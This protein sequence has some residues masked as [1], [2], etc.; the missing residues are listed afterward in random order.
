M[1]DFDVIALCR[2]VVREMM[3]IVLALCEATRFR[4]VSLLVCLMA[5]TAC[6]G[7]DEIAGMQEAKM[8]PPLKLSGTAATGLALANAKLQV[9]CLNARAETVTAIDGRYQL[10][11][12]G[13]SLPCAVRVT[14]S[15]GRQF[16]AIKVGNEKEA[17]VNVTPLTELLVARVARQNAA[18][19]FEQ[20][21][22]AR[23]TITS[24]QIEAA[25]G[26]IKKLLFSVIDL[27]EWS[28]FVSSKLVAAT[29]GVASNDPHDL[30][31]ES[32]KLALDGKPY[33]KLQQLLSST[34]K[35]PDQL[36]F[37]PNLVV[38]TTRVQ[39][40]PNA[41]WPLEASTNMP[42]DISYKRQ[43][44]VWT[45]WESGGGTIDPVEGVYIAPSQVGRYH[46][47]VQRPDY[48]EVSVILIVDVVDSLQNQ[49]FRVI[50]GPEISMR[51]GQTRQL[52][53]EAVDPQFN[54]SLLRWQV[55]DANGGSIDAVTGLY[56]A[57]KQAGV[58][59]ISVAP[60]NAAEKKI[61]LKVRVQNY[62]LLP[63][64]VSGTDAFD[65]FE[66]VVKDQ[67]AWDTVQQT[68][69][70]ISYEGV[71]R[72]IDFNK[73]MVLV[74]YRGEVADLCQGIA[75]DRLDQSG[76]TWQ[77]HY[78]WTDA[79]KVPNTVCAESFAY[80]VQVLVIDKTNATIQFVRGQ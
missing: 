68:L 76:E 48:P 19:F 71:M 32:L 39:L 37:F 29:P 24:Q 61:I 28:D 54:V 2:E 46:I 51:L 72:T 3:G 9:R 58:Y 57:P 66:L 13:A 34:A 74:A 53:V 79:S 60:M 40:L 42:P 35:L 7:I 38:S 22:A 20:F 44:L 10:S 49:P 25:T 18:L 69:N 45:V 6:G 1:S 64:F 59:R 30:M 5:L 4:V 36:E 70:L 21:E 8:E 26:E 73:E 80:P 52:H 31:L 11:L 75:V 65:P 62:E 33:V 78:R 63:Y 56:T 16:H 50:E 67:T 15:D 27:N 17:V 14:A 23:T 12:N 55:L 43:P 41:Q 47:Q 77:L